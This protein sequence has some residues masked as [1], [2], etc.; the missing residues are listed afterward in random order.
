[1]DFILVSEKAR[2]LCYVLRKPCP[3]EDRPDDY[4]VWEVEKEEIQLDEKIA[5]GYYGSVHKGMWKNATV[6]VKT[7]KQGNKALT[8]TFFKEAAIMKNLRHDNL[9]AVYAVCSTNQ[10]MYMIQ[11]HM[12]KGTLEK[13]LRK[14]QK[15]LHVE[16]LFYIAQ[17]VISGIEYLDG[18]RIIHRDLRA[19]NILIGEKNIAKICSENQFPITN[20]L[21]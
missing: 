2:G 8:E 4:D 12:S 5:Q 18:Q 9:V 14:E 13:Y 15:H 16:D 20:H 3:K 19:G 7:L 6:T 10:P 11:E 21:T 1:M 17:Q